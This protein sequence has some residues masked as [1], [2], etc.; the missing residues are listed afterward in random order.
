MPSHAKNIFKTTFH[1]NERADFNSNVADEVFCYK[2][3]RNTNGNTFTAKTKTAFS[4]NSSSI[5]DIIVRN[6][7]DQLSV[8]PSDLTLILLK[9]IH[10]FLT[11]P[12]KV[13]QPITI[14]FSVMIN[15]TIKK[16]KTIKEQKNM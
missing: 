15:S 1:H 16:A 13:K 9:T 8:L 5:P 4:K 12:K 6:S 11:L 3:K 7:S 10:I 14:H 2:N